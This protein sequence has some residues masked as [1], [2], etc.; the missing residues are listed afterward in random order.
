[1]H[2]YDLVINKYEP[3]CE[4]SSKSTLSFS[5]FLY[6]SNNFIENGEDLN[7]FCRLVVAKK[8]TKLTHLSFNPIH[9]LVIAGD[10]R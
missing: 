3:I 9:P 1:M 4:Q 8:K 6:I 7:I 2:V 5:L 10:D